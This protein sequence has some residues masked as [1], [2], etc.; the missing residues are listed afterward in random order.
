MGFF[1]RCRSI[2]SKQWTRTEMAWAACIKIRKGKGYE[3]YRT[4]ACKD[5]VLHAQAEGTFWSWQILR[6]LTGRNGELFAYVASRR[7][8]ERKL[9]KSPLT[10]LMHNW[11]RIRW[12]LWKMWI[13]CCQTALHILTICRDFPK[14]WIN[15]VPV[16]TSQ[17]SCSESR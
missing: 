6:W 14:P 7:L 1:R 3:P 16:L 12:V 9:F 8:H 15:T 11:S 4:E 10:R 17:L 13:I 5:C 2:S